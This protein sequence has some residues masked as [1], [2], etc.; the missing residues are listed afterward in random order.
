M[1]LGANGRQKLPETPRLLE[2]LLVLWQAYVNALCIIVV[3]ENNEKISRL[4]RQ[5][6]RR[7]AR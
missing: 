6:S 5:V 2:F 7:Q 3:S 4:H 1:E